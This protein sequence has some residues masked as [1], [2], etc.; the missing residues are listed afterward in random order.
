MEICLYDTGMNVEAGLWKH[1]FYQ[2]SDEWASIPP[3][4]TASYG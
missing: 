2:A 3:P 4:I 1:V